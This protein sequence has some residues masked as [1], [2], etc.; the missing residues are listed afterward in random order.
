[1]NAQVQQLRARFNALASREKLMVAGA[2]L[3]IVLAIVWLVA[4][5]PALATLRTAGQQRRTLDVQL[6]RMVALKA[7]AQSLQSQPKANRDEALRQLEQSVRQRL[8]T[9]GRMTV[10]GDRVTV[11]LTGVAGD[12]L[13]QWLAQARSAAHTLPSD[14]HLTRNASGQWEGTLVLVLPRS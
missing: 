6:Q 2:A 10:S 1:M 7:Q 5:G 13:A 3:V 4:V 11:A 12:A 8:G 14:A 9:A